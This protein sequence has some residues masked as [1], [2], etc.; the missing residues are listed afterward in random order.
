MRKA[1]LRFLPALLFSMGGC[2]HSAPVAVQPIPHTPLAPTLSTAA[3]EQLRDRID[4]GAVDRLLST[5]GPEDRA[6]FLLSFED[7]EAAAS[8][9]IDVETRDVR[10]IV[11]FADPERQRILEHVWAPFWSQLPAA[12]LS[13]PSYPLPGRTLAG[14][15]RAD[16]VSAVM[17]E[18][19]P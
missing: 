4:L 10:F 1:R 19:D 15:R 14:I 13:D 8:G 2:E 6:R 9:R 17:K 18:R 12:V 5:L 16:S 11:Q 3:R 7:V